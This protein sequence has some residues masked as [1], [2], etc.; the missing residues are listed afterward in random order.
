MMAWLE[1]YRVWPI[2]ARGDQHRLPVP[3]DIRW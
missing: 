2:E 3:R 1:E